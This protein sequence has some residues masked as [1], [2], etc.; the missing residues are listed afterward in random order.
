MA[1]SASPFVCVDGDRGD[2]SV[3]RLAGGAHAQQAA[4]ANGS[5]LSDRCFDGSVSTAISVITSFWRAAIKAACDNQCR[6]SGTDC[7]NGEHDASA[8]MVALWRDGI[9][10]RKI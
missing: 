4:P 6:T 7:K 5:D 2:L 9:C 3:S 1:V 10:G 8:R